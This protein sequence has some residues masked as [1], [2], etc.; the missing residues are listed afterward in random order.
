MKWIG[1]IQMKCSSDYTVTLA[2]NYER[3]SRQWSKKRDEETK[4][5]ENKPSN[6]S[7]KTP[8]S[9]TNVNDYWFSWLRASYKSAHQPRINI[10]ENKSSFSYSSLQI[11]ECLMRW[12][13][14][15]TSIKMWTQVLM[16]FINSS[17]LLQTRYDLLLLVQLNCFRVTHDEAR[18]LSIS[19]YS[20]TRYRCILLSFEARHRFYVF[21]SEANEYCIRHASTMEARMSP[22]SFQRAQNS[23]TTR[24]ETKK[25]E[26]WLEPLFLG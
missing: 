11:N 15:L 21:I 18:A 1:R 13:A 19:C 5:M 7:E 26:N 6:K 4:P 17:Q 9:Y 20:S 3:A 10:S 14:I 2:S 16:P 24:I 25:N 8:R 23:N 22:C 12:H